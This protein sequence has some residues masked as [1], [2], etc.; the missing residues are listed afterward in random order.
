M[1]KREEI[2]SIIIVLIIA[3]GMVAFF[4]YGLRLNDTSMSIIGA[5]IVAMIPSTLSYFKSSKLNKVIKEFLIDQKEINEF[6]RHRKEIDAVCQQIE[7]D[8]C[9]IFGKYSEINAVLSDYIIQINES[10]SDIIDKK[11]RYD[12]NLFD[13][14]YFKN[15]LTIKI[16]KVE[17]DVNYVMLNKQI[18]TEI[19]DKVKS[20]INIYIDK[21]ENIAD[22]ENGKRRS[23]FKKE[24]LSL[25][26]KIADHSID[27]YKTLKKETA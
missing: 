3:I 6:I 25:T 9:K 21:I 15:Q 8:T 1:G 17:K 4:N 5:V 18:F 26:Q 7:R 27:I 19:S 13:S 23:K 11:Y 22:M 2:K 24:T 14:E 12:F 20:N 16:N 10:I